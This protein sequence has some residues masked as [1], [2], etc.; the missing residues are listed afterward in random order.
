[1]LIILVNLLSKLGQGRLIILACS[2]QTTAEETYYP[3]ERSIK[4]KTREAH[5]PCERSIKTREG[6]AHY[7]REH[8]MK[9]KARE[10]HYPCERSIKTKTREAHYPC[11]RS[12]KTKAREAHYP[13]ERSIKTWAKITT[14][15]GETR[16]PWTKRKTHPV[17]RKFLPH[18]HPDPRRRPPMAGSKVDACAIHLT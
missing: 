10:A 18:T 8:S 2:I 15:A 4:T 17:R 9:T 11:E 1:M 13:C 6:E 14:R 7:P 5:C 3:R 16:C 12:I